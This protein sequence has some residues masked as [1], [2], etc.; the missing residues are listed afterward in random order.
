MLLLVVELLLLSFCFCDGLAMCQAIGLILE[1]SPVRRFLLLFR[2]AFA[3]GGFSSV[4]DTSIATRYSTDSVSESVAAG[5]QSQ[6]RCKR[7]CIEAFSFFYTL[8]CQHSS[9]LS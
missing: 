9:R 3:F 7:V 2:G 8:K 6:V 4:A 1:G 5:K